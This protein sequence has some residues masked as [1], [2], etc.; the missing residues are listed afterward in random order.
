MGMAQ[1]S[2]INANKILGL[3]TK[4]QVLTSV[5]II[6]FYRIFFMWHLNITT[7]RQDEVQ[8][9]PQSNVPFTRYVLL[10]DSGYPVPALRAALWII[11][12]AF[13]PHA[14]AIVHILAAVIC[15][16][17]LST[18]LTLKLLNIQTRWLLVI[19][20]GMYPSADLLLWHNISYFTFIGA[21][22]LIG[23][24]LVDNCTEHLPS[25]K[26]FWPTL[27][28]FIAMSSKPQLL[29][30]IWLSLLYVIFSTRKDFKKR[31]P[32]N[33][34]I[35]SIIM[36]ITL[37]IIFGRQSSSSLNLHLGHAHEYF[38]RLLLTVPSII[39]GLLIPIIST[40]LVGALRKHGDLGALLILKSII[41]S[42]GALSVC[43][44]LLQKN[45]RKNLKESKNWIRILSIGAVPIIIG[46]SVFP[47]S[48]WSDTNYLSGTCTIC[49]YQRHYL[50]V[51]FI[52]IMLA[53]IIITKALSVRIINRIFLIL[54]VQEFTL[55]LLLYGRLYNPNY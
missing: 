49:L 48:G 37:L 7:A 44:T 1:I 28:L 23:K 12:R 46:N 6:S 18:L 35:S 47:N 41:M 53:S 20:L 27:I 29:G 19:I 9:L 25:S 39:G 43:Y 5:L 26:Y 2:S 24:Y 33:L 51:L 13:G 22:V 17:S 55:N 38:L 52:A 14:I 31:I 42:I 11:D 36:M 3:F 50:P 40:A 21:F 32:I 34:L 15:G 16:L 8:W 10:R 30:A 54:I 4:H 45:I